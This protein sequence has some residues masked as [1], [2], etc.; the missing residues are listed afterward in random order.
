MSLYDLLESGTRTPVSADNKPDSNSGS[1]GSSAS[2][3][4]S[5]Q[6]KLSIHL[7]SDKLIP[8][9][10]SSISEEGE[11]EEAKEE[12]G[13]EMGEEELLSEELAGLPAPHTAAA[14]GQA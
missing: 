8:H 5:R 9:T 7:S 12:M 2:P 14:T 13:M 4:A 3:E 10:I 11:K 6:R 1:Q